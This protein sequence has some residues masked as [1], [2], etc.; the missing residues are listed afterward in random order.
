MV[1]MMMMMM[2]MVDDDEFETGQSLRPR[3]FS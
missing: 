2:M 1:M 3:V